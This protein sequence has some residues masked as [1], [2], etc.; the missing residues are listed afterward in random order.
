MHHL[1]YINISLFLPEFKECFSL[2]DRDGDGLI[3]S[4]QMKLVMRSLGQCPTQT[5]LNKMVQNAGTKYIMLQLQ[6]SALLPRTLNLSCQ[7]LEYHFLFNY[8]I[9]Q[10]YFTANANNIN[11]FLIDKK[12]KSKFRCANLFCLIC[13]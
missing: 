13:C 1:N 11:V 7:Y 10:F 2:Y 12:G 3:S 6:T 9:Q 8:R 5:E 4:E